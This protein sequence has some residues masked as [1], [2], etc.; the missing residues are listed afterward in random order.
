M[1][2][3][4]ERELPVAATVAVGVLIALGGW[5]LIVALGEQP[6]ATLIEGQPRAVGGEVVAATALGALAGGRLARLP[7]PG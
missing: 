1:G 5:A 7:G 4:A 2:R 6:T 3:V